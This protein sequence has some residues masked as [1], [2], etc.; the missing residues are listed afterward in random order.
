MVSKKKIMSFKKMVK[1]IR[2]NCENKKSH[3]QYARQHKNKQCLK[4]KNARKLQLSLSRDMRFILC[5]AA[6]VLKTSFL[7]ARGNYFVIF[8]K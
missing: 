7:I 6:I 8:L 1:D 3:C 4:R 5:T 2:K